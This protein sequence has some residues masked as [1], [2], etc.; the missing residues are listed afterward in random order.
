MRKVIK[1]EI[2]EFFKKRSIVEFDEEFLLRICED[3]KN[4]PI[5]NQDNPIGIIEKTIINE[6]KDGVIHYGVVWLDVYSK[7]MMKS[8]KGFT[9][10]GINVGLEEKE[11]IV[12]LET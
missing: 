1:V 3:S 8:D 12:T 11:K 4:T 7:F 5:M 9:F 10:V 6:T 2:P